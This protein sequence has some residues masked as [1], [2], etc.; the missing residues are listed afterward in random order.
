MSNGCSKLSQNLFG[1][2]EKDSESDSHFDDAGWKFNYKVHTS[3]ERGFFKV[4][5]IY[6]FL[7]ASLVLL[8]IKLLYD[9]I[10]SNRC[11]QFMLL[12]PI[13]VTYSFKS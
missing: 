9:K 2:G 8:F 4:F 12:T 6:N 7:Y 3:I 11:V 5:L 1:I 13:Y 10:S